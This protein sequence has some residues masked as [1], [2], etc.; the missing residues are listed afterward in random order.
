MLCAKATC[1]SRHAELVVYLEFWAEFN[2][3]T[4]LVVPHEHKSRLDH[5]HQV[6]THLLN[7]SREHLAAALYYLEVLIFKLEFVILWVLN[8]HF[9]TA[10][11]YIYIGIY[12]GTLRPLQKTMNTEGGGKI[13]RRLVVNLQEIN[14]FSEIIKSETG[15]CY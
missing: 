5:H 14:I 4:G 2:E 10:P 15:L 13:Q 3:K 1:Q 6:N 11:G 9:V 7:L 12:S 8:I